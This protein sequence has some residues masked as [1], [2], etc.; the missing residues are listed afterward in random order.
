MIDPMSLP[1]NILGGIMDNFPAMATMIQ[2]PAAVVSINP[3]GQ[4]GDV[5][6]VSETGGSV[7]SFSD[8][9]AER[10][11]GSSYLENYEIRRIINEELAAAVEDNSTE[12]VS[13]LH[14]LD[15]NSSPIDLFTSMMSGADRSDMLAL[16]N[17][18]N[19]NALNNPLAMMM[20]LPSSFSGL[21]AFPNSSISPSMMGLADPFDALRMYGALLR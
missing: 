21:A 19:G 13:L 6:A 12:L 9:L 3:P 14:R 10:L 20:N 11:A 7:V 17:M 4:T 16:L 18:L 1:N 8:A 15:G 2:N 5:T